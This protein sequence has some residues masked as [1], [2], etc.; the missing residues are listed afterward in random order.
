M[1]LP[2]PILVPT[3]LLGG[4]FAA[5][6][7]TY[8]RM[9]GMDAGPGTDL[10][11]LGW[12][13]GIWVPMM[14]A[15]MLPSAMRMVLAFN[16]VSWER[17][18]RQSVPVVPTWVFVAGYLVAWTAYGILAYGVYRA[19]KDVAPD[20]FGWNRGGRY[21]AG[22]ALVLAGLYELAPLKDVC[23]RRCRGPLHFIVRSWRDG[24]GGSLQLGV[25]HGLYCVGCC[26]GLMLALFAL[27]VMSLVWM[28]VIAAVIFAE[29]VLSAGDRLAPF[30]GAAFAA[31]GIWVAVAPSWVPGL[32]VP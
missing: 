14:A 22:S 29:K 4:A 5:W 21:V 31:L 18:Q 8:E 24:P 3:V 19:A 27:G 30:V 16:H 10:G 23:L 1:L 11:S 20:F 32:H 17:A 7:V 2:R 12:Y 13:L 25:E 9:H 6:I 15:M 26:W 28:A